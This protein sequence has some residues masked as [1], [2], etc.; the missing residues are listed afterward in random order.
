MV[1]NME[2]ILKLILVCPAIGFA[3]IYLFF[4]KTIRDNKSPDIV[5][6]NFFALNFIRV[7]S[8]YLKIRR[9][10]NQSAGFLFYLHFLF[11]ILTL[12][13]GYIFNGE[14]ISFIR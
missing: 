10:N 2:M 5:V 4:L 3:L 13:L 11:I 12:I 7:Y 8:S 1:V 9:L 6:D 14:E